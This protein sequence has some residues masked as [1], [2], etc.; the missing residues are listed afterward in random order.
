[1]DVFVQR[2]QNAGLALACKSHF[3][4]KDHFDSFHCLSIEVANCI[5]CDVTLVCWIFALNLLWISL[6]IWSLG[7]HSETVE[8]DAAVQ[9]GRSGGALKPWALSSGYVRYTWW[10]QGAFHSCAL[11]LLS[12]FGMIS[13]SQEQK[14]H[15]GRGGNG[16]LKC[17]VEK[18]KCSAAALLANRCTCVVPPPHVR[19]SL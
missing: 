14:I 6:S 12:G 9:S 5:H 13:V 8:A 3:S 11:L 16:C 2:T 15:A 4:S 18:V 1:M 19:C 10:Y 17:S 7:L